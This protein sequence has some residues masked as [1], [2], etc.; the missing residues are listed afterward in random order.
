M[1]EHDDN[2]PSDLDRLAATLTLIA[3]REA[4]I[5][6]RP[7][8]KEIQDW[9]LGV[10][11]DARAAEV[12]THV[13]RDPACYQMWS[14]LLAAEATAEHAQSDKVNWLIALFAKIKT[15]LTTPTPI[16]V[17][18]GLATAMVVVLAVIITPG[19]PDWSPTDNP[20]NF[21]REANWPYL[22]KSISRSGELTYRNKI[23]LQTGLSDGIRLSTQGNSS[24]TEAL[25]YLHDMPQSCD[26]AK[27]KTVCVSQTRL[28]RKTGLH[29]SVLYL[30]CLEHESGVSKSFNDKF[31]KNQTQAWMPLGD[32]LDDN[33]LMQVAKLAHKLN[34][35]DRNSQCRTVRDVISLAF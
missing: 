18:G 35:D 24:W 21:D 6:A 5:G 2:K 17:G 3:D 9:H 22:G 33:N 11:D 23:A 8:L 19:N 15:W 1:A 29:A 30:A 25:E 34:A 16:W 32:E 14:E 27:D 4:P 26:D 20:V 31:W 12:K 28:M 10:L 7:D 13:A